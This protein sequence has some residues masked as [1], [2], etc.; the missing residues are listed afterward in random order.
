MEPTP[1]AASLIPGII[2]LVEIGRGGAGVVYRGRQVDLDREV[3]VKVVQAGAPGDAERRWRR[4]VSALVRV[5]DHPGIVAVYDGGTTADGRPYLVM[6]YLAGGTLADRLAV[7]PLPPD[8]VAAIGAQVASALQAAHDAGVL[9]RDVKPANVLLGSWG[10]P[11]LADFG[12]ARLLDG[13]TTTATVHATVA[14]AAPEVLSGQP[15]TPASD[16]YGLGA[17][18]HACLTGASPFVARDG[19]AVV[20]LALRVI[21]D[22]LPDLRAAGVDPALAAVLEAAT[23]KDPADRIPTAA[24]LGRRLAALADRAPATTAVVAPTEVVPQPVTQVVPV[25]PVAAAVAPPVARPVTAQRRR[26]SGALAVLAIVVLAAAAI[27]LTLGLAGGGSAGDEGGD[28]ADAA[29]QLDAPAT[30][31]APATTAGT[32]AATEAAPTTAAAPAPPVAARSGDPAATALAYVAALAAGDFEG[33]YAMTT[34]RFQEA[35]DLP[36]FAAFWGGFDDIAVDGEPQVEG[37]G[38]RV[39]LTLVLGGQTERYRIELAEAEDGTLLVDG[40]RPR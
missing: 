33:A 36:G 37:N 39:S 34:P 21:A 23:A 1:T 19:E 32:T 2:D 22:P 26:S 15:A 10:E 29:A 18:L 14:Y 9:H 40:P 31:Q 25:V 13:T 28:E 35:Q 16:V 24:E 20:A 7:A 12:I 6:P 17:T 5:S 11:Q 27:G 38:R 4:E 8:E 3:A 30:T